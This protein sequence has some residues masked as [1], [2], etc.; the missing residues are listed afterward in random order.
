MSKKAIANQTRTRHGR[1]TIS[2]VKG[3]IYSTTSKEYKTFGAQSFDIVAGSTG[4]ELGIDTYLDYFLS[5][6]QGGGSMSGNY[7][8]V[9][10]EVAVASNSTAEWVGYRGNHIAEAGRRFESA[11]GVNFE[12]IAPD[13][14]AS[15]SDWVSSIR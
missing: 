6:Y 12:T 7:R 4:P 13:L 10:S 8:D 1:R 14:R 2:I 5:V 11:T 9:F 15:A 3:A